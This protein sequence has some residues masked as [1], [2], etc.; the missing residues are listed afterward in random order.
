MLYTH[1]LEEEKFK[2]VVL[3]IKLYL[4]GDNKYKAYI[5]KLINEVHLF[6]L[7]AKDIYTIDKVN[8]SMITILKDD[9]P[10]YFKNLTLDRLEREDYEKVLELIESHQDQILN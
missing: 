9:D 10:E 6:S 5:D 1:N 3:F 4:E 8:F 2:N 7:D